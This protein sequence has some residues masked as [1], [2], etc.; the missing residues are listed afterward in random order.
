MY[1]YLLCFTILLNSKVFL[2]YHP[3]KQN[4]YLISS[5]GGY[6]PY[7]SLFGIFKSSINIIFVRPISGPNTPLRL[8]CFSNL[9]SNI[10]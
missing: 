7:V 2:S 8:F 3:P 4:H 5:K 6:A 10:S 9:L 1:V